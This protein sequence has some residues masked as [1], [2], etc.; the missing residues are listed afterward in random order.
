MKRARKQTI[1]QNGVSEIFT[2]SLGNIAQKVLI[3]GKRKNL[4]LV[5]TFHGGPGSPIPFSVGCRGMFPEFTER[6]LMVYW[7][8]LGCGI[9]NYQLDSRFTVDSFVAMAA[10]LIVEVKKR[11]PNNLLILFG[12]SWGSVLALKALQKAQGKVN[13]V[14]TWGQVLRNLFLNEEVYQTLEK[15]GCPAGKMQKIRA[16]TADE[17]EDQDMKLLAGS[18]RKYTDGYVNKKGE[19]APLFPIIKGLLTSPDYRLKDFKAIMVNGASTAKWLWEE[20]L[21]LDLTEELAAVNVPYYI[22]Q[23]DTDI[24]TSTS[25][26]EREVDASHNACLHCRVIK[27]SGHMPGKEGMEAVLETLIKAAESSPY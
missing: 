21:A 17:F 14:V 24:V 15:A 8:Q 18:V 4:P 13:A 16:I 5:I 26:I 22:L 9:N 12:M 23:G 11:F 10:D 2:F 20:L 6:F 1:E 25:V 7:D 27:N 3:E 19:Q